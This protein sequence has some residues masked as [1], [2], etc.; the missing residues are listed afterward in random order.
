MSTL[1]SGP[2][3]AQINEQLRRAHDAFVRGFGQPATHAAAAPGRVNLIGEHTDYNDGF[4]LPMAID[5]QTL[6]LA[7]PRE[8]ASIRLRSTGIDG[9]ATLDLSRVITAVPS[10][11]AL[12]WTNY[13]R[14]PI[15]LGRQAGLDFGG[16][17]CV[18][19]S[20]VPSGGGLS[21]SASLEVTMLTLLEALSGQTLDPV[22]K[23]LIAQQAEHEFAG[24]P[25]GIMDQFISAMG[26]AGHALLIDCRDHA[27]RNIKLDGPDLLV[28]IINSKVKHELTGGEYAERRA[29][30]EAAARTLGVRALRDA[31]LDQLEQAGSRLD[32]VTYRRARHV[33][34]E[35]Q[36]TLDC[37]EA[38]AR[39]DHHEIGRLMFASH[40]SLRDD[41]EV[42]TPQL[43][44]LV[45]LAEQRRDRGVVGS[46][47]TGGG[48][49]GC[50]VSLVQRDAAEQIAAEITEQYHA[51]TG[52]TPDAFITVPSAGAR[53]LTVQA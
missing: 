35:N 49:G 16:F 29:Q 28:L 40:A 44:A 20:T 17:D 23:A 24:M 13:L 46:R 7:R 52:V 51:D 48:F 42:S 50:T 32:D 10:D 6:A 14:G 19:D 47:M 34:G 38:L 27:T 31:T 37:A 26:K 15:E 43:D 3:D 53:T 8:D 4:V 12:S 36:R 33:I 41:F 1:T 9:Q 18:V 45:D 21:S 30:C 2:A 11:D 22:R 5:R 39:D 25:C